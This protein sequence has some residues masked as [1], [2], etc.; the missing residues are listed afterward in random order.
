MEKGQLIIG[1]VL[2]FIVLMIS[3]LVIVMPAHWAWEHYGWEGLFSIV[4]F[5]TVLAILSYYIRRDLTN[6]KS[7]SS[8]M[9]Q[10]RQSI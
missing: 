9:R 4:S 6:G 1:L 10:F 3:F 7:Q 5:W 8:Q 2:V